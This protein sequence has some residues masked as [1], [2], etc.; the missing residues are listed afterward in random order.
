VEGATVLPDPAAIFALLRETRVGGR[1]WTDPANLTRPIGMV[2][3]P[4]RIEDL[5]AHIEAIEARERGSA[6]WIAPAKRQSGDVRVR[7]FDASAPRLRQ[8][9]YK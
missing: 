3:R 9:P 8:N 1:F 6:L 4:R 7:N 5:P 2:L